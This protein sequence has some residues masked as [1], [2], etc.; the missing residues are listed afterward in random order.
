M[1]DILIILALVW[2]TFAVIQDFKYREIANWLNFSLIIF[3]M[4]IRLFYSIFTNNY[5]Y[6]LFGLFGLGVFFLIAH[7]F[8][9]ARI[10]AGGDAKLLIALGAVLPFANTLYENTLIFIVFIIALLFTGGLYTLAYSLALVFVNKNK[11]IKEFKKQFY[12]F[13]NYFFIAIAIAFLLI[14]S[15]LILKNIIL[16]FLSF[17]IFILPFLFIYTKAIEKTYMLNYTET[18][19]LTI[20]DWLAEPI[21]INN[22]VIEPYWEGLSEEQL[23]LIQTHY[24]KKVLL[25]QGIPF[26]PSFLMAFLIITAIKYLM[27]SNW[28][29]WGF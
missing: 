3:A 27:N 10:F 21:T 14:I 2:L 1:I 23:K 13:K 24:H 28:G 4:A 9:Y 26:S 8:Y 17:I 20:G 12:Q 5:T 18:S 25:K 29:L 16:A 7:L 6:I 11:F 15:S 19:K 22:K